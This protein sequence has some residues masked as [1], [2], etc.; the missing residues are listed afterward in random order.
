MMCEVCGKES[1]MAEVYLLPE[2]RWSQDGRGVE[3]AV[4]CSK[5]CRALWLNQHK[6]TAPSEAGE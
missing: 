3:T 2:L 5:E 1:G 4:A 6:D